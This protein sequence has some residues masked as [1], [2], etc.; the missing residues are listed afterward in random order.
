MLKIK[1]RTS[2]ARKTINSI[3]SHDGY[4]VEVSTG[5]KMPDGASLNHPRSFIG[6]DS[7]QVVVLNGLLDSWEAK[8]RD[9]YSKLISKHGYGFS[10]DIF[11]ESMR[12]GF[13][14]DKVHTV[15]D[16]RTTLSGFSCQVKDRISSG[17]ITKKSN[18]QPYTKRSLEMLSFISDRISEFVNKHGDFDFGKYNLDTETKFGKM[19][20]VN[21]YDNLCEKFKLFLINDKGYGSRCIEDVVAKT[22]YLI[23]DRCESHGINISDRY[24]LKLRYRG[25]QYQIVVSLSSEQ[26]EWILNN[27]HRIREDNRHNKWADSF[28]DYIIAALLTGARISD[29]DSLTSHNLIKTEGGYILSYTPQKTRNSSGKTV[30]VPVPERLVKIFQSN[31]DRYGKLLNCKI[32]TGITHAAQYCRRIIKNYE[33]FQTPTQV[34]DKHG[35]IVTKPFWEAFK[36]HGTRASLITYLLSAGE[37][38]TIIKSIS[39]HT[40]DSQ[41]F[42]KYVRITNDM[43]VKTMQ[44]IAM[45]KVSV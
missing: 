17:L 28:I 29:L 30:E 7:S 39:G 32:D 37:Q 36:F 25:N 9:R 21:S 19:Y 27:E 26:F 11:R 40:L 4:R 13:V 5:I 42:T 18:G 35:N 45:M 23:K 38:E 43:K 12:A 24:L 2:S 31:S 6:C 15:V 22:K 33:I 14:D 3:L 16:T 41:S 44:R 34:R 20:I 1:Y 10:N 8:V